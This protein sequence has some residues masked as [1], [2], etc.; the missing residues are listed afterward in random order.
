M[1]RSTVLV[2]FAGTV[3][4]LMACSAIATEG[5]QM[6]KQPRLTPTRTGYADAA[7]G[8]RVYYEIYGKGEPIVVLAGG[9]GD[10]SSMVQSIGPLSRERRL[11]SRS[12][13]RHGSSELI[14]G[15]TEATDAAL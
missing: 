7:E 11:V 12:P 2:L 15:Q 1:P 5:A 14:A 10:T 13:E 6:S 9:F 8:L 4:A 3:L